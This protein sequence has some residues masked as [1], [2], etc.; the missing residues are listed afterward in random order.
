MGLYKFDFEKLSP[1]EIGNADVLQYIHHVLFEVQILDGAL[2]CNNCTKEYEIR[3][4][5]PNMV[6]ADNEV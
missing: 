2:V 3:D 4:G 6:L 1:E 5:V